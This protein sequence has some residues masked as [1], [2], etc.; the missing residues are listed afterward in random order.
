MAFII[1]WSIGSITDVVFG[2]K[3]K[4]FILP[5]QPLSHYVQGHCQELE[6]LVHHSKQSLERL[7]N[8]SQPQAQK[9]E[10]YQSLSNV[11]LNQAFL[12]L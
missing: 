3:Q 8:I 6:L 4:I 10:K 1:S 11:W 12:E 9:K 2:G 7:L 5:S